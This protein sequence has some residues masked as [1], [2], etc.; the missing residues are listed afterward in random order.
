MVL[1]ASFQALPPLLVSVEVDTSQLAPLPPESRPNQS[2]AQVPLPVEP[3]SLQ[4]A[5]Q[6]LQEGELDG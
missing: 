3:E 6:P 4:E 1:G 2:S 5:L